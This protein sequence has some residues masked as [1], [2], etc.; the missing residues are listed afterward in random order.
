MGEISATT[1]CQG[2]SFLPP[3]TPTYTLMQ[4][5]I[6]KAGQGM[7][8]ELQD[9]RA[10]PEKRIRQERE[11]ESRDALCLLGDLLLPGVIKQSAQQ[12]LAVPGGRTLL[13]LGHVLSCPWC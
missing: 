9:A 8:L 6:G 3:D 12:P 10:D 13:A 11:D 5:S 2:L 1:I 7:S 4:L